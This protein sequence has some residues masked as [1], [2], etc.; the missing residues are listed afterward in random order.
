MFCLIFS[1]GSFIN[2]HRLLFSAA[3]IG[4]CHL[5]AKPLWLININ[6]EGNPQHPYSPFVRANAPCRVCP[7]VKSHSIS[8]LPSWIF[9]L[10]LKPIRP[11]RKAYSARR[12]SPFRNATKVLP[13]T[14]GKPIAKRREYRRATGKSPARNAKCLAAAWQ[15]QPTVL[16]DNRLDKRKTAYV[17]ATGIIDTGIIYHRDALVV[18]YAI[19]RGHGCK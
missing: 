15:S 12:K 4:I 17:I 1:L 3:K 6:A 11:C 5:L 14:T 7:I 13:Q 16:R 9:S 2:E 10:R 8:H 19:Q 18:A